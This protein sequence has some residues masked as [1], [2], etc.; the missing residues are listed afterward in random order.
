MILSTHAFVGALAGRLLPDSPVAAFAVGFASHF[1]LDAIPHWDYQLSSIQ[2]EGMEKN[3]V[4]RSRAFLRDSIKMG[5]DLVLA[6]FMV[7]FAMKEMPGASPSMIAGAIGGF[8][9]DALQF[10]FWK[11]RS[12]PLASIQ[13]FHQWVH[14]SVRIKNPHVGIPAQMAVV[15]ILTVLFAVNAA[16]A[17]IL[18]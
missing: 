6:V 2:G 16:N 1:L 5:T 15:I 10:L 17:G 11:V 12:E 14:T 9:P 13:R 3:M 18:R 8:S 4:V 7:W